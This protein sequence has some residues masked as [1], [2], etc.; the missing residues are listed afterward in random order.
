MKNTIIYHNPRCSKSREALNLL[1]AQG[2]NITVIKYLETPL[3]LADL[4]QICRGLGCEPLEI[5]RTHEARFKELG[6]SVQ[7]QRSRDEWLQI[8]HDN[9]IL[10]E[11]PI[12]CYGNAYA[13][14]RPAQNILALF[15]QAL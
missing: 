12:V 6:L 10:I 4:D 13:L 9:P 5:M 3:S 15:D 7:D 14:G 2:V 1:G 11:R 8:L